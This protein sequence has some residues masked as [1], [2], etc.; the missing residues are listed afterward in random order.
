MS[1]L[2]GE[3]SSNMTFPDKKMGRVMVGVLLLGTFP[4]PGVDVL[5]T[6]PREGEPVVAELAGAPEEPF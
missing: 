6:L 4:M 3:P 2:L 1:V 5:G